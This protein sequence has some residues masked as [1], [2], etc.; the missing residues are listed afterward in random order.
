MVDFNQFTNRGLVR[1]YNPWLE[2]NMGNG[3]TD[4]QNDGSGPWVFDQYAPSGPISAAT[5]VHLLPFAG[6]I[7]SKSIIA[8]YLS[9][10]FHLCGDVD[11]DGDIDIVD[12][13]LIARALG[14]NMFA[15]PWGK[16]WDYYD[17]DADIY[18]CNWDL[19]TQQPIYYTCPTGPNAGKQYQGDGFV[20]YMEYYEWGYNY[21]TYP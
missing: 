13:N 6:Y 11:G 4:F 12:G 18:N 21:G 3:R 14:T 19:V 17:P 9:W 1:Q 20:N 16:L 5:A 10:S 15:Y 2:Y 7:I 8:R